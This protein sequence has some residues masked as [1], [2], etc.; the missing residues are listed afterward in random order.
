MSFRQFLGW[1]AY[2]EIEPI[3]DR[4]NAERRADF[5]AASI[6]ATVMNATAIHMQSK[7]RFEV[8][9]FVLEYGSA[10]D[11]TTKKAAPQRQTWQEQK[12]IAQMMVA[13]SKADQRKKKRR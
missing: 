4:Q 6:C 8:K 7:T 1:I 2:N 5:R 11:K 13:A 3:D 10:K 12:F 9:D